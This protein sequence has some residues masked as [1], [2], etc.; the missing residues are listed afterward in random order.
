MPSPFP[1][2]DPYLETPRLWPDVHQKLISEMQT[3]LN[4]ALVPRYVARA[5]LRV[6]V[7]DEDDPARDAWR[8]PDVRIERTAKRKGPKTTKRAEALGIAEPLEIPFLVE[9]EIEEAF[10]EIHHVES[11]T[12]VTVIEVLCPSNKIRGSAGRKSFLAK[13]RQILDSKVHWVEIDLLQAGTPS[14]DRLAVAFSD[15]RIVVS[16]GENRR[17]ARFWPVSL[18]R[19]LPIISI[20]LRGKD[21]DVLLDLNAVLRTAYDNAA[22]DVSIDYRRD[23]LP[24]LSREDAAWAAKL[25]REHGLR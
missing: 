9:D 16:R 18:R 3:A 25:L 7:S 12:T 23:P 11:K 24:P 19:A 2:M 14:L 15:Y 10:L 22:Y 6:Y 4:P 13:R 20:P 1:G 8:V 21:P 17:R 5:E